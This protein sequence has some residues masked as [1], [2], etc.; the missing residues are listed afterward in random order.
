MGDGAVEVAKQGAD[1]LKED[2]SGDARHTLLQR[3]KTTVVNLRQRKDY[4]ESVST[5]SL[6]IKRYATAYSRAA[7]ETV[8]AV[9][10]DVHTSDELDDAARRFWALLRSFGE[11]QEWDAL[12]A[13]MKKLAEHSQ[14]NPDFEKLSG[15]L[16]KS[17]ERLLSD[18]DFFDQAEDKV[19]ELQ[20]K[21]KEVRAPLP[22]A[23]AASS[24]VLLPR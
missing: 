9:Q 8:A 14:T 16:G 6:L 18:P 11:A 2:F 19:K 7:D 23:T 13:K 20:D 3:L 10:E 5:I 4:S 1:T 12:E 22:K 17:I 15:E 21:A 24:R